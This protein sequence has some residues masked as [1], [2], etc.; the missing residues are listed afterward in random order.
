VPSPGVR[1]SDACH[2]SRQRSLRKVSMPATMSAT[3]SASQYHPVARTKS[4]VAINARV[5]H[6]RVCRLCW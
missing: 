6:G 3:I 4:L 1:K 2:F 5:S